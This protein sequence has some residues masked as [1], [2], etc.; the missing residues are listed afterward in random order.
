MIRIVSMRL[1]QPRKKVWRSGD[2]VDSV[3]GVSDDLSDGPGKQQERES[4]GQLR[5]RQHVQDEPSHINSAT[6]SSSVMVT[7]S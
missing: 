4:D 5:W 7:Y 1:P 2:Q 6:S 3:H